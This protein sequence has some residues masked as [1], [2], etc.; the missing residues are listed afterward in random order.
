MWYGNGRYRLRVQVVTR[1]DVQI[2]AEMVADMY[3]IITS[4]NRPGLPDFS[5]MH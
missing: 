5:R 1:Q 4:Q 2:M 3:F